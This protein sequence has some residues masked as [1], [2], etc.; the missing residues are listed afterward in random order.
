MLCAGVGQFA[1]KK[2]DIRVRLSAD[3]PLP[4]L[5]HHHMMSNNLDAHSPAS[6]VC[7]RMRPGTATHAGLAICQLWMLNAPKCVTQA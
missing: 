1:G 3:L 4:C 5:H 2:E 7:R 6:I